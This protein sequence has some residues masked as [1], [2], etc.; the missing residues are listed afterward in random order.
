MPTPAPR[1]RPSPA[2][3]DGLRPPGGLAAGAVGV[4]EDVRVLEVIA[5]GWF[6]REMVGEKVA[7]VVVE[8]DGGDALVSGGVR[9]KGRL[10]KAKEVLPYS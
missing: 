6:E 3:V 2:F 1:P 9:L 10:L 8:M 4:V 7:E 5:V